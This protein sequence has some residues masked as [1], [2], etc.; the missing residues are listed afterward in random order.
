M[1]LI[2]KFAKTQY[3]N[4]KESYLPVIF[5]SFPSLEDTLHNR[6]HHAMNLG[7]E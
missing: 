1:P 3:L 6:H 4:F 2:F 5:D 7:I